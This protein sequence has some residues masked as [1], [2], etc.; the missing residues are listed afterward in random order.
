M[1]CATRRG[2]SAIEIK[3]SKVEVCRLMTLLAITK[4]LDAEGTLVVMTSQATL[5][6]RRCVMHQRLRRR[7]LLCQCN[8]GS[9][10]MAIIA[11]QSL[12]RAVLG[13]TEIY[14]ISIGLRGSS[15]ITACAMAR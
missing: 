12:S 8:R 9:N 10:V 3:A 2:E 15:Q 4:I 6:A 1:N 5:R 7:D 14:F 13:V 11:T